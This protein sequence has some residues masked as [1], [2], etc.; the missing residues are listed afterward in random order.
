MVG[1]PRS[2]EGLYPP[3]P[4]VTSSPLR[5]FPG[6]FSARAGAELPG[7]Y[8]ARG[9]PVNARHIQRLWREERLP[10]PYPKRN[11]PFGRIGVGPSI[12]EALGFPFDRPFDR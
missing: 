4:R 5:A 8:A 3:I 9:R 1:Q 2:T 12:T 6:D 11:A 10:M 7:R